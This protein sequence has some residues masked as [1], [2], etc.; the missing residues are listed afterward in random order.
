MFVGV[1]VFISHIVQIKLKDWAEEITD[2]KSLYIPYSSDKTIHLTW[3]SP[4]AFSFISHIVQIKLQINVVIL[5]NYNL[6]ISH[7]VQIKPLNFQLYSFYF[8]CLYI[9]YSSDKTFSILYSSSFFSKIFI[10]HIV[11]IKLFLSF[12]FS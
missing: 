4:L 11:Q 9:P 7:I 2:P 5:Q 12:I 6:F 3:K 10:S 1:A 8:C